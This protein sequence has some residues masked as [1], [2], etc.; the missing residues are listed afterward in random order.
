MGN[1]PSRVSKA[2]DI[3]K[4]QN[5]RGGGGNDMVNTVL[6]NSWLNSCPYHGQENK[7]IFNS[8]I[9]QFKDQ[10]VLSSV[11]KISILYCQLNSSCGKTE[12]RL[13]PRS[14]PLKGLYG[15]V[16]VILMYFGLGN[17]SCEMRVRKG[18][19]VFVLLNACGF[20]CNLT[21]HKHR[22]KKKTKPQHLTVLK[23]P[24]Y[25]SRKHCWDPVFQL[26]QE[27]DRPFRSSALQESGWHDP[28]LPSH[29]YRKMYFLSFKEGS[30]T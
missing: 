24:S 22:K 17:C 15:R 28:S 2:P 27:V 4:H 13:A 14:F 29:S 8:G 21:S 25:S 11:M 16:N 30:L 26:K 1:N 9:S 19:A 3:K 20:H 6:T 12:Y 18:L 7:P 5:T 10:F 23:L